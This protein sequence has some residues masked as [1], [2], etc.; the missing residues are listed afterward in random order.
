M[1]EHSPLD[2]AESGIDAADWPN[3]EYSRRVDCGALHWHVQ[4]A[5]KG[6]PMLLVHGTGASAH[7]FRDLIP[8]LAVRFTVVAPD[9][10]GHGF[11][12][13]ATDDDLSLPGM[14]RALTRLLRVLGVRPVV[15]VGHSA[16]AA[17]LARMVLDCSISPRLLV[18]LNAALLP[19][20]GLAGQLFLPA[21][22]LLAGNPLVPRLFAWHAAGHALAATMLRGT[23]S[24]ID[25]RGVDLYARLMR[26][27]RHVA[28][29]LRMMASWDVAEIAVRL[30]DLRC[31][32]ALLVGTADR[33]VDPG[34]AERLRERVPGAEVRHLQGLG[35]LA[36]EERPAEVADWLVERAGAAGIFAG[37]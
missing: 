35:H 16:G 5:G 37:T 1:S 8:R 17:V 24:I 14:A 26:S 10:P 29:V 31:P 2:D 28:G 30:P 33:T 20:Q 27:P 21:A 25:E 23:G 3:R 11:T 19:L 6:P 9:L 7:S 12:R 15:V 36:H 13:G 34:Q 18:G 22:R 32:V 4:M